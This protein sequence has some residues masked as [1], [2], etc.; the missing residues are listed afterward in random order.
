M[1]VYHIVKESI[2]L[3]DDIT[4]TTG[5]LIDRFM[6]LEIPDMVRVYEIFCRLSKQYDELDAFYDWCKIVGIIRFSE[7][8]YV[9]KIP[10]KKL[11]VMDDLIHQKSAML[12]YRK[13]A[14][15]AEPNTKPVEEA[16]EVK[17][18]EDLF[19]IKALP[20][21]EGFV[22]EE[23]KKPKEEKK[24]V[25]EVGDLLNLCDDAPSTEEQ[26]HKLALALF[27]GGPATAAPANT[28]PPWEAFKDSSGD[29]EM[30]LVESVSHLSNQKASLAGGFDTLILD[31][32]YQ[33]GEMTQAVA[34]S[35]LACGSASSVALGSAGRPTMLALPAPPPA[36]NGGSHGLSLR[37][38][39]FAASLA[40]EP[41]P[42]VQMSEME[43]KQRFLVQEQLM[44]Q[45]YAR[46]G[47]HGQ[48]QERL[49]Y[50]Y[51]R[52]GYGHI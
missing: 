3:Y 38:D 48:G 9:E 23:E 42:Y 20:P 14:T 43:K 25:Q 18:Q 2:Q 37:T 13:R 22:V 11:D 29:W 52:G 19:K 10:Q 33:H 15:S 5:V 40:I 49:P 7:Y 50:Q 35:S 46:N 32:M 41:P 44:W 4:E 31:G 21:C 27:N 39:P 24:K 51:N 1:A 8:P 17:P 34:G 47:M 45:Q 6:Q 36:A 30:A 26:G 28:T 16:S 12:Q